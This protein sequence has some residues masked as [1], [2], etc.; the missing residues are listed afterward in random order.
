MKEPVNILLV[1]LDCARPDHF[2][3]YGYGRETTPFVDGLAREGVR[4]QTAIS[5]APWTLPAHGSLFTGLFP[6]THGASDENRFLPR[7]HRLLPEYLREAGYRTGMFCANP[8]V[9][10]QTGFD[11]GVDLFHT[12][13]PHGRLAARTTFYAR[14][15]ADR[16]LG[17]DDSG[18]RRTNRALL[19]WIGSGRRPFFAFVHYNE[20]HLRFH[21]PAPY[22]RMFLSGRW[23]K[24]RVR[25]VNQDCNAYIA[26][27]VPM[28]EEDFAILTALYDGELR[29]ADSRLAEV[30]EFLRRRGEWDRTLMIVTADHG[31]NLGDHGMMSHKFVLYD[32]LIRIPLILRCPPAIPAGFL[33][34]ELAQTTDILPTILEIAGVAAEAGRFQGRPLIVGGRATPGPAFT[35]SERSRPN[36][37]AFRQ[38]FPGFD[39]RRFDVIRKA[40]RTRREKFIWH[41]S[42]EC[43]FYDLERDPGELDNLIFR[44]R[45]R[46]E[47]L[48]QQLADW[49]A[50][51]ERG[52]GEEPPREMDT[53]MRRQLERLGYL[54]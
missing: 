1:V 52:D 6:T 12:Q 53:L 40:I 30:A 42:G 23:T 4:V 32:T 29:Y 41:S 49:A 13:R 26:G 22:D 2:S 7:R 17:R 10:P 37:T 8:W 27:A 9:S 19:D 50:S 54:E 34:D 35:I 21:P 39:A 43:E 28:S 47:A 36:L 48:R 24:E 44:E 20:T 18:A 38:R 46:S 33:L 11:R 25:R 14:K 45:Q 5:T 51:I 15:A 3:C 31:E 16:L